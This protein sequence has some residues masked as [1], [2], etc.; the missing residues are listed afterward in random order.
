MPLRK[1]KLETRAPYTYNASEFTYLTI[2]LVESFFPTRASVTN[3]ITNKIRR[4]FV[5]VIE[6]SS[7]RSMMIIRSIRARWNRGEEFEGCGSILFQRSKRRASNATRGNTGVNDAYVPA[8][9]R[10][11]R[12]EKRS[13]RKRTHERASTRTRV[14]RFFLELN[15][16][17][18][19]R[20]RVG[21]KQARFDW[22]FGGG[23]GGPRH[24]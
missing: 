17:T 7:S 18:T 3:E 11:A 5:S 14:A 9:R 16:P 22:S 12:K 10:P 23:G 13:T 4:I 15:G 21:N 24:L 19:D 8:T 20:V 1:I 6:V 2:G